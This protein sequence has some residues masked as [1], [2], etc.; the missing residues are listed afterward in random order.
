MTYEKGQKLRKVVRLTVIVLIS[1]VIGIILGHYVSN[2]EVRFMLD[3][4]YCGTYRGIDVYKVGTV[5]ADNFKEHAYMLSQAPDEL[6]EACERMYF[7]GTDLDIPSNDTGIN[8]ALGLT[9][10]R[11]VYISTRTFGADVLYHELFHA[12]DNYNGMLSQN[13]EEFIIAFNNERLNVST[14]VVDPSQEAAEFFAQ[15]GAVYLLSPLQ[16]EVLAPRTYS[17]FNELL[18]QY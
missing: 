9:Q 3:R 10:D 6:V 8:A 2:Y 5:N 1:A 15:A 13:S 7:T 14:V 12:Y 11:T 16:L 4:K 18:R 17:F